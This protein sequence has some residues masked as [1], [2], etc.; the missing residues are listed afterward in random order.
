MGRGERVVKTACALCIACCGLNVHLRDDRIVGIKGMPEHPVNRGRICPKAAAIPGY[1]YAPDRLKHPLKKEN[2]SWKRISWDEALDTIAAKL[3]EVKQKYSARALALQVGQAFIQQGL[4]TQEL[5]RRFTDVYGTPNVFNVDSL[6]FRLRVI[7]R[8]LTLGRMACHDPANARCVVLWAH[9]PEASYPPLDWLLRRRRGD[10]R[11][12][13]IDVRKTGW[14]KRAD[15]HVQ[16]RPG[17]DAAVALSMINVIISEELYDREIVDKHT[18]GFDRLAEHVKDYSP[19]RMEGITRVPAAAVRE[20]ARSFAT[21]RPA[22]IVQGFNALDQTASGSQASRA[23]AI[24][25]VITGNFDVPG[26]FVSPPRL[27]SNSIRLLEM[28]DGRPLGADQYPANWAVWDRTLA[29]G[30]AMVLPDAILGGH[31]YPV[32]MMIVSASNMLQSWPNT[33]KTRRALESLEF[34]VVMDVFKTETAELADIVLPA[35]TFLEREE[36]LDIFYPLT[37]GIPYVM[38]RKKVMQYE[39][40]WPDAEFWFK[41]AERMGYQACF[42]WKSL[43][44]VYDYSLEPSELTVRYLREEKPEGVFYGTTEYER[45]KSRGV[46]TPS[47]KIEIYSKTLEDLGQPPLPVFIE[48]HESPVGSPDLAREYP[49]I[50][51][52]GAR[53]REFLHS[54]LRNIPK[55]QRLRPDPVAQIHPHTAYRYGIENCQTIAIETMRGRIEMIADVTEDILPDVVCIPHGWPGANANILTN[56]EPADPVVGNPCLKALLCR[57]SAKLDS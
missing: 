48:P 4:V 16:P 49:L 15:L 3:N 43:E 35:A 26:G 23:I 6:C 24:L 34:L 20:L 29:E 36:P 46:R 17:T 55:L 31:P 37:E 33:N 28:L 11:L 8:I 2:G 25:Q 39:E 27:R 51:T 30:Q 40:C 47:G 12:I 53:V 14:A 32:K 54:Q 22:C 5:Q 56:E 42:P 10:V 38:L 1:A 52:T 18:A 21:T 13:V 45:Y 7:N 50:L 9:N 41:L 44:E 19:E 57:V